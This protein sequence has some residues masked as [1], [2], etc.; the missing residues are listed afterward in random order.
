MGGEEEAIF[1]QTSGRVHCMF[2]KAKLTKFL[3]DDILE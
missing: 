2:L 3:V 1:E